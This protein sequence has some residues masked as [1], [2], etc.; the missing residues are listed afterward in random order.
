MR[1]FKESNYCEYKEGSPASHVLWLSIVVLLLGR[2]ALG[3][4]LLLLLRG[5]HWRLAHGRTV[6]LWL[7]LRL[8]LHARLLHHWLLAHH[9]W[10]LAHRWLHHHRL[11]HHGLLLHHWLLHHWLLHHWLL[12]HHGLL[13]GRSWLL[14]A[15]SCS[16]NLDATRVLGDTC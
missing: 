16:S 8:V 11:L 1:C 12:L 7:L 2:L 15:H 3:G 14:W 5:H 10:L 9:H 4:E 6:L 13:L